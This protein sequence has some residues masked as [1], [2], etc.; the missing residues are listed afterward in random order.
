MIAVNEFRFLV[1]CLDPHKVAPDFFTLGM[2]VNHIG[3]PGKRFPVE[4]T[5]HAVVGA[6]IRPP[7]VGK[8]LDLMGWALGENGERESIPGLKGQRYTIGGD[9]LG[10]ACLLYKVTVP[11]QKPGIHGFDLF[12]PD[13]AFGKLDGLLATYLYSIGAPAQG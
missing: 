1:M 3:V 10:P 9:Q 11:F 7:T 6:I 8:R 13:G 12:D 5:M 4:V 2:V